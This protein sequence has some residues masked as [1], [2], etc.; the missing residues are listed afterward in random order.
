MVIRRLSPLGVP[1]TQSISTA[2]RS[3][4][5]FLSGSFRNWLRRDFATPVARIMADRWGPPAGWFSSAPR[6]LIASFTPST[7]RRESCFGTRSYRRRATQRRQFTNLVA[8]NMW[9]LRQEAARMAARQVAAIWHSL[10]Q[11]A[12][13]AAD[14]C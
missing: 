6:G 4:G 1:S 7:A 9:L 2:A 5:R 14:E 8:A 12:P 3:F 11:Q 13:L 10:C